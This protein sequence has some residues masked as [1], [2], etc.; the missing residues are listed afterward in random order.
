MGLK[1]VV[2]VSRQFS[3][4]LSSDIGNFAHHM[5]SLVMADWDIQTYSASDGENGQLVSHESMHG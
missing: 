2:S 3:V 1:P 4:L 5:S